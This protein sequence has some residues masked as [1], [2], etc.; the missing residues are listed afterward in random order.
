MRVEVSLTVTNCE[1]D[2]PGSRDGPVA[3]W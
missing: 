1:L 3:S 2:M